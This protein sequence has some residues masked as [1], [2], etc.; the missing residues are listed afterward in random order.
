MS[1][2][3]VMEV[4][5]LEQARFGLLTHAAKSLLVRDVPLSLP[6]AGLA[7]NSCTYNLTH[8]SRQRSAQCCALAQAS[9]CQ[10]SL[11]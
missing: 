6:C 11:E 4:I 1:A 10:G 7:A 3:L 2:D 5:A 9:P 8:A